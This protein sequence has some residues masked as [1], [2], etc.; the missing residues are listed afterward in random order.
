MKLHILYIILFLSLL[1]RAQNNNQSVLN[2]TN[3]SVYHIC[4]VP[5]NIVGNE[6]WNSE[7]DKGVALKWDVPYRAED[8]WYNT[9]SWDEGINNF[10]LGMEGDG[11]YSVAIRWDSNELAEYDGDTL[12]KMR[13]FVA[14]EG[15]SKLI[16][17]VWTGEHAANNI[18][19]DTISIENLAINEWNEFSFKEVLTLDASKEYWVGYRI[20]NQQD[21]YNPVG[22]W[23]GDCTLGYS[24]MVSFDA[25]EQI[26][27]F[28]STWSSQYM[29]NIQLKVS[30]YGSEM[31]CKGFVLLRQSD[32]LSDYTYYDFIPNKRYYEQPVYFDNIL[33]FPKNFCYKVASLWVNSGDSCLSGFANDTSGSQDFICVNYSKINENNLPDNISIYPNPAS[34]EITLESN[35]II[36]ELAF[37]NLNGKEI[38]SK[39]FKEDVIDISFLKKG[40]YLLDIKCEQGKSFKKKLIKR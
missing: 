17:K 5:E 39:Q 16:V 22:C 7:D 34:T 15:F 32:N 36:K 28:A 14:D 37:Y 1:A 31:K 26:W 19:A 29:W 23:K 8:E 40:F 6:Y 21:G 4:D 30:D 24:D 10:S 13:I 9:L 27:D 35:L 11:D 25:E 20:I 33:D 38:L 12:K 2:K 18:Y 3:G